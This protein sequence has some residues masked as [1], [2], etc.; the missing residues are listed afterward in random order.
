MITKELL[1]ASSTCNS[2]MA[3]KWV[4]ALNAACDKYDITTDK[5]IAG[6][7]SQVG[8]ESGGLQLVSEN[9]NYSSHALMTV[10]GFAGHFTQEEADEYQRQPERIANRAYANRM[11]NGDEASGDGWKYRGQG[12]IQLT[13]KDN[14]A[15]FFMESGIDVLS[16]PELLQQPEAGAMAAGW[17]W[18]IKNINAY[19]DVSDV[20]G[21]T[22]RV[23]GGIN[24]LDDRQMRYAH[25]MD[26]FRSQG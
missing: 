9:L 17:F 2:A 13:G 8:H 12:P 15:A 23:N 19:A 16:H 18:T 21:M 4:D 25:L 10:P 14:M 7:L 3:D 6:F 5:R 22:K 26:Y 11:G 1:V 20:V 24:G